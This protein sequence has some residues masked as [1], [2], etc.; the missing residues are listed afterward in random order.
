MVTNPTTS[1]ITKKNHWS[2]VA[3]NPHEIFTSHEME[4]GIDRFDCWCFD[5]LERLEL[6][7]R[8]N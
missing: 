1:K 8:C 7:L 3:F 4:E 2:M 6:K 5:C